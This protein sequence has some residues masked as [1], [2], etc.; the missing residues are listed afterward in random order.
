M[1]SDNIAPLVIRNG[2]YVLH[3]DVIRVGLND[4]DSLEKLYGA[5][6]PYL[7]DY[8]F[9]SALITNAENR[10][11][12]DI[13]RKIDAQLI[14]DILYK[15]Y[16]PDE[17]L[18]RSKFYVENSTIDN[19]ISSN[20]NTLSFGDSITNS[21]LNDSSDRDFLHILPYGPYDKY[22]VNF[23]R[24]SS[25]WYF[26]K[27][28]DVF[29]DSFIDFE[30]RQ[31]GIFEY[32][33]GDSLVSAY[34]PLIYDKK[35]NQ[36][37]Y[38][39]GIFSQNH[40]FS[41][42]DSVLNKGT[43]YSSEV[44]TSNYQ[45]RALSFTPT[46]YHGSGVSG[47]QFLDDKLNQQYNLGDLKYEGGDFSVYLKL[48]QIFPTGYSYPMNELSYPGLEF[49][50]EINL[51]TNNT[52]RV[53]LVQS[54]YGN[55]ILINGKGVGSQEIF[56][57]D[58]F[59]EPDPADLNYNRV[60]QT[61]GVYDTSNFWYKW[62]GNQDI[63]EYINS[64]HGKMYAI[65]MYDKINDGTNNITAAGF[66]TTNQLPYN[67][68]SYGS[69]YGTW[70]NWG[71]VVNPLEYYIDNQ[72]LGFYKQDK[73][74]SILI[75]YAESGCPSRRSY[76]QRDL[77]KVFSSEKVL[78]G[79]PTLSIMT[80]KN[81]FINSFDIQMTSGKPFEKYSENQEITNSEIF[82]QSIY[83]YFSSGYLGDSKLNGQIE[84][85]GYVNRYLSP[86]ERKALMDNDINLGG[87]LSKD[88][89]D[90]FSYYSDRVGFYVNS[91]EGVFRSDYSV[92]S[93]LE[94][95]V[96][97]SSLNTN[98]DIESIGTTEESQDFWNMFPFPDPDD[99]YVDLVIS[100]SGDTSLTVYCDI[101]DPETNYSKGLD[102]KYSAAEDYPP[103]TVQ[104]AGYDKPNKKGTW[105][106]Y[107]QEI[108][109][110]VNPTK[111]R[112][113][114]IFDGGC[115]VWD[116]RQKKIKLTVEHPS[117]GNMYTEHINFYAMNLDVDWFKVNV[118]I[119][120]DDN[121]LSVDLYTYGDVQTQISNNTDLYT[122]SEGTHNNIDLYTRTDNGYLNN[123]AP[124]FTYSNSGYYLGQND[125]DLYIRG[126]TTETSGVDLFTKFDYPKQVMPLF[127]KNSKEEYRI[128]ENCTLTIKGQNISPSGR[129]ADLYI[130]G[131]TQFGD[132]D[133]DSVLPLFLQQN[134]TENPVD[135]SN[136]MNLFTLGENKK[137][138]SSVEL[139]LYNSWDYSNSGVDLFLKR[140]GLENGYQ[141]NSNMPLY[142]ERPNRTG[143]QVALYVL[144]HE[145]PISSGVDMYITGKLPVSS[146]SA[147]LTLYNNEQVNTVNLYTRGFK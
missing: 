146:N 96:M 74:F 3:D 121:T 93:T 11:F 29:S 31:S 28:E 76:L 34:V 58:V 90:S 111:Y 2:N 102:Y 71:I 10:Q 49:N 51:F 89:N 48:N 142:I 24:K 64:A 116:L 135:P 52:L 15:S 130:Y 26:L 19:E 105:R 44:N 82:G 97:T 125:V 87:R 114:G 85:F 137:S 6:S 60:L 134:S 70:Y 92:S 54:T 113:S 110:R 55:R 25:Y 129:E 73:N 23:T 147:D 132:V 14:G 106:S 38:P 66:A 59:F 88:V 9:S 119:T 27:P 4:D 109:A 140:E 123:N 124:L 75:S 112:L 1:P 81:G 120:G 104:Y 86:T 101:T 83:D 99:L 117:S 103:F 95:P 65:A 100:S 94:F 79:V 20:T 107:R 131:T 12:N 91:G 62:I 61:S 72:I 43:F 78:D 50:D 33:N 141:I 63:A 136:V 143:E 144:G 56:S 126:L 13:F 77:R 37:C 35:R 80:N 69:L 139:T 53:S 21:N 118:E 145:N 98:L 40:G 68:S 18:F 138:N 128:I 8:E 5:N 127:L 42:Y 16:S 39:N 115:G 17:H 57:E 47:H 122:I 108:P 22:P 45:E 36:Y 32:Q 67:V 41:Y 133:P 30:Q 46:V 7:F 84:S